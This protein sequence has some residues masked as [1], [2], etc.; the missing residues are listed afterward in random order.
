MYLNLSNESSA[1]RNPGFDLVA[2][3]LSI[4]AFRSHE[5][6]WRRA[7]HTHKVF[8]ALNGMTREHVPIHY[9]VTYIGI[10]IYLYSMIY[11]TLF[12]FLIWVELATLKPTLS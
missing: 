4:R 5:P 2:P 11:H 6:P 8:R 12:T 9:T 7:A 3:A 1:K 10:G